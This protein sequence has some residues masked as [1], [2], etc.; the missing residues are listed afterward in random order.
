MP[1]MT[2]HKRNFRHAAAAPGTGTRNF[3]WPLLLIAAPA[4]VAIW[5]GWVGLGGL[6]GFGVIH[7]LPGIWD[8]ARIDTSITLPVGVEAYGAC[9][10]YVWLAIRNVGDETRAFAKH[11]AIGA[12]GL[13][14]LG[15]VAFHLM[16]AA[17]WVRAPWPVVAG[18]AC[19]PVVTVYFGA[20]LFHRVWK[21]RR[22]SAEAYAAERDALRAELDGEKTARLAAE[23]ELAAVAAGLEA[24]TE[25]AEALARKLTAVPRNRR[26]SPRRKPAGTAARKPAGAAA[27][28]AAEPAPEPAAEPAAEEAISI[29][30]E[31]RILQLIAEGHTPSRA[32]VLAG[33]SDSYG[34][35]IGR[36][37]KDLTVAAPEGTELNGAR[38]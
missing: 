31:M 29:D 4:A 9:A 35:A 25:R 26:S 37:A 15:Q 22:D 8:T 13:G 18:V 6:C 12:L 30:A 16:A 7:P 2:T 27:E 21:D 1:D 34:R 28:P 32:G 3:P 38:Q 20:S 17:G 23:T 36:K 19:L 33:K 11:S 5:S 24:M 10:L 14:C